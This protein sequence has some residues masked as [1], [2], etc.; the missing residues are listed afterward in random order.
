VALEFVRCGR[1][2]SSNTP[3]VHC[4]IFPVYAGRGYYKDED[5]FYHVEKR[6]EEAMPQD[7]SAFNVLHIASN[8]C[9]KT[10][11][12]F[13]VILDWKKCLNFFALGKFFGD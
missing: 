1:I 2:L 6:G 4:Y 7:S 8:P 10:H 3:M 13:N 9:R 11:F 5:I 12:P